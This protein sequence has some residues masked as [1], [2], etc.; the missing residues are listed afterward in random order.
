MVDIWTPEKRFEVM[1]R[2]TGSDTGPEKRVRSLL[3]ALGWHV[4]T[5]WACAVKTHGARA[6]L[7]ERLPSLLGPPPRRRLATPEDLPMVAEEP[8]TWG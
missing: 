2:I 3:H 7:N 5:I 6:W 1:A 8:P 4:V